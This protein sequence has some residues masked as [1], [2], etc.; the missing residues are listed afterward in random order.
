ML[1]FVSAIFARLTRDRGRQKF[2]P[3]NYLSLNNGTAIAL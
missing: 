2:F 3:S 1:T